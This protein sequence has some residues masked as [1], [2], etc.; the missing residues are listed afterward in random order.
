MGN[1][2]TRYGGFRLLIRQLLERKY[3]NTEY[4][5]LEEFQRRALNLTERRKKPFAQENVIKHGE[6]SL[7]DFESM[8]T[9]SPK[10]PD[11]LKSKIWSYLEFFQSKQMSRL[12]IIRLKYC[13]TKKFPRE[14][15]SSEVLSRQ[16]IVKRETHRLSSRRK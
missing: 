12:R 16:T 8:R 2:C 9:G 13:P 15:F 7:I 10:S 1:F 3:S 6:K 14:E 5:L 4:V 11:T